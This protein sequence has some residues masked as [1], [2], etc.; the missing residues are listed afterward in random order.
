[1]N[2]FEGLH[3]ADMFFQVSHLINTVGSYAN[4]QGFVD[5]TA[6]TKHA[7]YSIHICWN[8]LLINFLLQE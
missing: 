6:E 8:K 5:S 2:L 1:M 7:D 4:A 3:T